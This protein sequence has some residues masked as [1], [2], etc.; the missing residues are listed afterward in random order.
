MFS[1]NTSY[2]STTKTTPFNLLY[3]MK[4][5]LPAFPVE[6]LQRINYGEGFVAERMQLLQQ[7]R[8]MAEEDSNVAS[9]KYKEQHDKTEKE[10]NFQVG[11]EVLIDN[12]LFVS[13]NKKF[14]PMWIGPYK[15]TKIINKQNVEVKIK[16]DRYGPVSRL[17]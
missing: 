17:L 16:Q 1:Y 5:R 2:H 7:A 9:E 13:K 8:R 3:G 4:P 11:D 12:Q 10:H 15:I 6:E 14:S